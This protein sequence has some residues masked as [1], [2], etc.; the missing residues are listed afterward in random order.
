M[1]KT[2]ARQQFGSV[3]LNWHGVDHC[4]DATSTQRHGVR[5]RVHQPEPP[6]PAV[7]PMPSPDLRRSANAMATDEPKTDLITARPWVERW[8]DIS[9]DALPRPVVAIEHKLEPMVTPRGVVIVIITIILTLRS[10]KFC[11]AGWSMSEC[12]SGVIVDSHGEPVRSEGKTM[13][14]EQLAA[15]H[16]LLAEYHR[17]H[18]K[19]AVLD[20]VQQYHADLAQRLADEASQIPRRTAILERLHEREQQNIEYGDVDQ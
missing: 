13:T 2:E 3:H 20:I 5:H 15:M 12:A 1:S 10:S 17:K 8:V 14:D 9:Q 19:E 11:S 4:W 18:A 6:P 16:R 7:I